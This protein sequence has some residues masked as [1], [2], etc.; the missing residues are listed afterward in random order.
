MDNLTP[1]RRSW[2]MGRI[3]GKDTKIEVLVRKRLFAE[4]FR[5]RKNDKRYPGKPDVILPK[6]KTAI[7]INGCFWHRHDGCKY[8]TI[9]KTRTDFWIDKFNR[10]VNNDRKHRQELESM[11]WHVI[12]IWE[13]ELKRD[14]FED[15][16]Q[17]II[18]QIYEEREKS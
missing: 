14:Y 9:P 16:M 2:N 5:F 1:E 8:A 18:E 10:N 17:R 15:T 13:C 7:F 11:G 3:H 6:Y 4:G 12:T